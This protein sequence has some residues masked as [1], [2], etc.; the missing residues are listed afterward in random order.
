[1]ILNNIQLA[2]MLGW[3]DVR[4]SYRRSP[5]GPFWVTITTA[6]LIATLGF[7]FGLLF[8]IPVKEYLPY[9][10]LGLLL[11]NFINSVISEASS[12]FIGA[13]DLVRQIK[14]PI[15]VH[16][17]RLIWR[18][19]IFFLHNIVLVPVV[20]L[21]FEVPITWL[22]LF[23]VLGLLLVVINLGWIVVALGVVA[24]RFRDFSQLT[25][26]FL[27][28]FFYLTPVIWQKEGLDESI[29]DVLV[30]YNPFSIL[31]AIIRDP[32]LGEMPYLRIWISALLMAIFGW[33]IAWGI[34]RRYSSRVVYW[35]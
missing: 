11:W 29:V 17:L 5:I 19:F 35:L 30:K 32:L 13:A 27:T 28:V 20:F 22:M 12:L 6:V 2:L 10:T 14:L 31:I 24:T 25:A 4:Q 23:S 34:S 16:V 9:L 15:Y 18:A 33:L 21:I 3:Q 8:K 7:V 1:M 26:S